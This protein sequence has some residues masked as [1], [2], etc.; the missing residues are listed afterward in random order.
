MTIWRMALMTF[1]FSPALLGFDPHRYLHNAIPAHGLPRADA[2]SRGRI[3]AWDVPV[4]W[5]LEPG[6]GPVRRP[7]CRLRRLIGRG[8]GC[9]LRASRGRRPAGPPVPTT[10]R[11][12][13]FRSA[14]TGSDAVDL[15][16][17]VSPTR[18]GDRGTSAGVSAARGRDSWPCAMEPRDGR[19]AMDEVR[20]SRGKRQAGRPSLQF[21]PAAIDR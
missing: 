2:P 7:G 12:P 16:M 19:R 21:D 1:F 17:L 5:R 10:W 13:C 20:A 8:T 15:V 11:A 14:R 3:A 4:A 18:V 6:V 9:I